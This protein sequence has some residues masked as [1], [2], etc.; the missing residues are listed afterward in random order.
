M[1]CPFL[2]LLVEKLFETWACWKPW[3]FRNWDIQSCCYFVKF[4]AVCMT[5]GLSAGVRGSPGMTAPSHALNKCREVV[6]LLGT[7]FFFFFSVSFLFS[8]LQKSKESN[9]TKAKK[10]RLVSEGD[11]KVAKKKKVGA[12]NI[13]L[14]SVRCPQTNSVCQFILLANKMSTCMVYSL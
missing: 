3:K 13:K 12:Q 2:P 10:R 9:P 11:T 6:L 1:P 4:P 7:L 14:W 8:W 5:V